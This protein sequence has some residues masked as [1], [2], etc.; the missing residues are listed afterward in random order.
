MSS[1]NLIELPEDDKT[2]DKTGLSQ[3]NL[4]Q[5]P[6]PIFS[7]IK[8]PAK[9]H[10]NW[11]SRLWLV[12]LGDQE[13]STIRTKVAEQFFFD[14]SKSSDEQIELELTESN[15]EKWNK[16]TDRRR[17]KHIEETDEEA[18]AADA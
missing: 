12:K 9:G 2:G 3:E 1:S 13:D 5:K 6:T 14:T 16:T 10:F 4:G 8:G 17:R 11:R 18:E 15:L 7:R